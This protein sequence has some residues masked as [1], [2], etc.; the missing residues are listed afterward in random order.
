MGYR[1]TLVE[2]MTELNE[3][4]VITIEAE[5]LDSISVI[6]LVLQYD[7]SKIELQNVVEAAEEAQDAE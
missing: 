3:E 2:A 5:N 7:S 6:Q 4:Q 1:E